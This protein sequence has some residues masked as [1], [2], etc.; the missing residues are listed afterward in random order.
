[1]IV[2]CE[3]WNRNHGTRTLFS[4]PLAEAETAVGRGPI[5]YESI[6]VET[7]E[8]NRGS[9]AGQVAVR[10]R[11]DA[12]RPLNGEYLMSVVLSKKDVALLA[13]SSFGHLT[14]NELVELFDN[15]EAA[16]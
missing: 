11:I 4:R 5:G 16:T 9:F 10:F 2:S 1:M 14:L 6:K 12:R 13:K 8:I 15:Q 7:P 3:G